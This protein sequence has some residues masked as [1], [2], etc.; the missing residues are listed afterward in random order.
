MP[1]WMALKN[2]E[3][4]AEQV[5]PHFRAPDGKPVWAREERPAPLT[6][7]E[8]AAQH[9]RPPRPMARLDGVGLVDTSVAHVQEELDA[10]R[11][12]GNGGAPT[13]TEAGTTTG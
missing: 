11:A 8:L 1:K 5:I 6:Q 12:A 4:M 7:T 10:A 3:I 13:P 9:G 2:M